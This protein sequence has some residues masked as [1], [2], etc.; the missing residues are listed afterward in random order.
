MAK[1]VLEL[2]VGT[3]QWDSGLKKAQRALN[4]FVDASGGL[5]DAL[6]RDSKSLT[7]FVKM[8]GNMDSSAKTARGQV[9]EYTAS[10]EQLSR[11][12]NSL[13][14]SEKKGEIGKAFTESMASLTNKAKAAKSEMDSIILPFCTALRQELQD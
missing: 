14:D 9:K 5:K 11:M 7:E 13:S 4:N 10:L 2:A 6:D 1:S 12:Y 3:G 8:M